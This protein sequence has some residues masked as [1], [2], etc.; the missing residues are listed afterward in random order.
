MSEQSTDGANEGPLLHPSPR[1]LL[2]RMGR[3][4]R[5]E[6]STILRDRR[7][8]ITLVLMP[9]LLYPLL[10]VAFRQFLLAS[11]LKEQKEPDYRLGFHRAP[12]EMSPAEKVLVVR[13][14]AGQDMLAQRQQRSPRVDT[15]TRPRLPGDGRKT[16][17]EARSRRTPGF[18]TAVVKDLEA[19]LRDNEI[20]LG[21]RVEETVRSRRSEFDKEYLCTILYL[22]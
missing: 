21:I 19:A 5:K 20:D 13:L 22:E 7:T 17:E 16:M 3:L 8:I 14:L 6:V 15:P 10:T 2:Q 11:S 9:L 4:V 18:Q 1:K 12:K